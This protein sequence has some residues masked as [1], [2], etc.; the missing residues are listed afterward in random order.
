MSLDQHTDTGFIN[1]QL[2]PEG[3][4]NLWRR[5]PTRN[6][7][8][9]TILFT[10]AVRREEGGGSSAH[11]AQGPSGVAED[12][13]VRAERMRDA[14]AKLYNAYTY[15]ATCT[16]PPAL[17]KSSNPLSM[18][19]TKRPRSIRLRE[20]TRRYRSFSASELSLLTTT[21]R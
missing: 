15:V 9:R 8:G 18:R 17:T 6:R 2:Q 19:K 20:K 11:G 10:R 13:H 4:R 5:R 21:T 1:R 7:L 14:K 3:F 16:M 12:A